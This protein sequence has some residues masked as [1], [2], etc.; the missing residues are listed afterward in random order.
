MS[1][2]RRIVPAED[3]RA[4]A[5]WALPAVVGPL[6]NRRPDASPA[7][8]PLSKA[9]AE[10]GFAQ[11]QAAGQAAG[12]EAGMQEGREAGRMAGRAE[13]D[14]AVAAATAATAA[15]ETLLDFLARPLAELEAQVER[16]LVTLALSIAKQ[17]VRRELRVDPA[18]IIAIVRETV[19]LLPA[20]TRDLRVHLHPEDAAVVR[21][22]LRMPAE[23]RAWSIAEDPVMG[24]GGCRVTTATASIDARLESRVAAIAATLLGEERARDREP[25]APDAG[26]PGTAP[27]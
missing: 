16:E 5:A 23:D 14:A 11:G 27:P 20:A 25:G 9:A 8:V 21:E 24:R 1:S 19:G 2:R 26:E 12:F 3:G 15:L 7:A 10:A 18:Q 22:R 4:L 13:F 17:L 6:V